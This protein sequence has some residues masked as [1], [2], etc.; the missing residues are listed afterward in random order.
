MVAERWNTDSV[1]CSSD[2]SGGVNQTQ[3]VNVIPCVENN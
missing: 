2:L 3:A 1:K